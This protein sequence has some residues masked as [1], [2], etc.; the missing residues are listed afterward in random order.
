[1]SKPKLPFVPP[2]PVS[3]MKRS[4]SYLEERSSDNDESLGLS[5]RIPEAPFSIHDELDGYKNP[6]GDDEEPDSEVNEHAQNSNLHRHERGIETLERL[7][8]TK[9]TSPE[10]S[11]SD[12]SIDDL[13]KIIH[14]I[15]TNNQ[16]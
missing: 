12:L 1:M 7:L 13:E 3:G 16:G 11:D 14:T 15:R 9:K 10:E 4:R 5:L 2:F 8:Q 6:F